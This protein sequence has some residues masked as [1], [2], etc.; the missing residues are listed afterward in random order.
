LPGLHPIG[1]GKLS[2]IGN[3]NPSSTQLLTTISTLVVAVAGFYF[4]SKST[5]EAAEA[6][7]RAAAPPEEHL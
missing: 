7:A 3:R 6:V 2:N 4:G 5:K 1:E